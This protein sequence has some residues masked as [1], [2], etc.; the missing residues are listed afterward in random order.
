[1]KWVFIILLFWPASGEFIK[2]DVRFFETKEDC[3]KEMTHYFTREQ[4]KWS[5]PLLCKPVV[6]PTLDEPQP[7]EEKPIKGGY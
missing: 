7:M 2:A 1:M 6:V 5:I 3:R 4:S